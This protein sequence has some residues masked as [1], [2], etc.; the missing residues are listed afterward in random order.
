[1]TGIIILHLQHQRLLLQD[2][3]MH[4][5]VQMLVNISF[6][7]GNGAS[8]IDSSL[9]LADVDDTNL[10]SATIQITTGYQIR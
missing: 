3:M 9:T 2:V 6:T 4:Q 1:M 5:Q 10:D 7:E 8:V